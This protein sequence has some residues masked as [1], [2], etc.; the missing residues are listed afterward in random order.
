M[1]PLHFFYQIYPSVFQQNDCTPPFNKES[2]KSEINVYI[3]HKTLD[4]RTSSLTT[5][6]DISLIDTG[7]IIN[8]CLFVCLVECMCVCVCG[9]GGGG[10]LDHNLI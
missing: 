10:L 8:L 1:T 4:K 6:V 3:L 9:G 2:A 7:D 5:F